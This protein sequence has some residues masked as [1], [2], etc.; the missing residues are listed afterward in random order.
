MKGAHRTP[1]AARASILAP[2]E[3]VEHLAM[4]H[5]LNNNVRLARDVHVYVPHDHIA[6]SI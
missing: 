4:T 6:A 2:D 5:A 1:R 3:D